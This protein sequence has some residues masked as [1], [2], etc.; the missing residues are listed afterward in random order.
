MTPTLQHSSRRYRR[1]FSLLE[2]LAT[3]T[4]MGILAV[5][6][7][8]RFGNQSVEVKK[9]A[10]QAMRGNLEVQAQL[11]FRT[12][13]RWPGSSLKDIAADPRYLPDGLPACPVD[14]SA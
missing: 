7:I 13:G 10:C 2:M 4:I 3:V 11:W 14:G 12:H 8:P 1:G 9:S 6:V 5:V